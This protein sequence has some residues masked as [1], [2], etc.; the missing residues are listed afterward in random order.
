MS[1]VFLSYS[2]KDTEFVRKIYKLLGAR[3]REAWI[4][5][6]DIDYSVKWWDEISAGI[7]GAN[8]FVLFISPNSLTSLFCHREIAYAMEHKKRIIP[9]L[10]K[11][12]NEKEIS[13]TWQTHPDLINYKQLVHDNWEKIQSI[14]WI[15]Y[16]K[17]DQIDEAV[18]ALLETVDTDP[19]RTRL[20][21]RLL[22][23]MR[24]WESSGRNPSSLLRGDEL[25]QYEEWLIESN[26][27]ATPPYPTEEQEIYIQ[28]SRRV[29][30]ETEAKRVRRERLVQ[31]FRV[32]SIVLLM[33]SIAAVVAIVFSI[34]REARTSAL[35]AAGNTQIAIIGKTL[36]PI[37]PALT[38]V[39]QTLVAGS[40]M[41]ESLNL[42]ADAI[43][44]LNTAGGNAETA[45]LLSIRALR[46]IYLES[47]DEA[48][49]EATSRLRSNSI[50]FRYEKSDGRV[51]GGAFSPDGKTFLVGISTFTKGWAELREIETG[52]LIWSRDLQAPTINSVSFSPDGTLIIAALGDNTAALWD[53][54]TG[55]TIRVFECGND[56]VR[57]AIF[58][59]DGKTI[60]TRG[61][62][63][64]PLAHSF[65]IQSGEKIFAIPID[66]WAFKY[67][68][69]GQTF[70][71]GNDIYNASNGSRIPSSSFEG[72]AFDISSEGQ[73]YVTGLNPT[74]EL[75]NINNGQLLH[76]LTGHTGDIKKAVFSRSGKLLVTTGEDDTA[77][78]WNTENGNLI[79]VLPV[80]SAGDNAIAISPDETKILIGTKWE[81]RIWSAIP[82]DQQN[83]IYTSSEIQI[84][85]LSPDGA[86]VLIGDVGGDIKLWD[87]FS[88]NLV[89]TFPER[90]GDVKAVAY[91]PDGKLVAIPSGVQG[92][93]DLYDPASGE[94][95]IRLSDPIDGP[96]HIKHLAF[97]ADGNMVFG[98]F[99][100]DIARLW[101]VS[102]GQ[103][104][105]EFSGDSNNTNLRLSPDGNL[106]AVTAYETLFMWDISTGEKEIF[107]ENHLS[108]DPV[109][110]SNDGSL[111]ASLTGRS[112]M[113]EQVAILDLVTKEI[114]FKFLSRHKDGISC[115]AFSP[116]NRLLLTGSEDKTARLWDISTGQLLRV[117]SGHHATITNVAFSPDGKYIV[118]A[119]M[120]KTIRTWITDYNGLIAYA[121][122]RV[123]RDFTEEE[124]DLYGISGQDAT[125]PQFGYLSQPLYPTATPML[126]LT[127]IPTWTPIPT[128]TPG[129]Q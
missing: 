98:D 12:I 81:A 41:I 31:R 96:S 53:A 109:E 128:P 32:A 67:F 10:I 39:A 95:V 123:G 47:A 127:P 104:L 7:D 28:E 56:P 36:T 63:Y 55:T 80:Q 38:A 16:T 88:G 87:L 57:K 119:S 19:D 35:V 122:T 14:Q 84:M 33:L 103:L 48:L 110:F 29:E 9:F 61:E 65:D 111:I 114:I 17:I 85:A 22:L 97:S 90:G 93:V 20:H 64:N 82:D 46:N 59:P 106:V 25:I 71:V 15:D 121:C 117:F 13:Q 60:L 77:R 74:A 23:R 118:T 129:N 69:H 73:M 86:S 27:A 108:A 76:T 5:L 75:R 113:T 91:S 99:Y 34:A 24:G 100:D 92:N 43:F 102:S 89:R 26:K 49:V 94:L 116:D 115:M 79:M 54:A 66:G 2:R 107:P 105:R 62:G 125:C 50:V 18:N 6:N 42:A 1:D 30:D 112:D 124:R 3:K 68:P 101:D 70:Q 51:N 58:S 21:T 78:L 40:S 37:P 11:N 120:D 83:I 8:N 4:D 52:D 72:N 44:E 126:T 45:A